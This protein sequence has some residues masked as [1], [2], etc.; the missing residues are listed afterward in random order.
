MASKI[1]HLRSSVSGK[2]PTAGQLE[3]G[4]IAL[5]TA[6][7]K[8][9]MKKSDNSI[10]EI[11]K[12]IHDEDT[13][14]YIDESGATGKI[15]LEADGT[16][17]AEI[18]VAAMN[19][20]VP[21]VIEDNDSITIRESSANGTSGV[22]IKV[23]TSLA[24]TY[25]FTLPP[26]PGIAGQI[27]KTNGSGTLT[28][29]DPGLT[30]NMI[31]VDGTAGNDNNDGLIKPVASIKRACEIAS[32]LIYSP[33]TAP[34]A[35]TND[36][37]QLLTLNKSFIQAEVIAYIDYQIANT[38]GIWAGFTY[39][40]VTCSRDT[41][42]IVDAVIYDLKYGGNSKSVEA[43]KAYYRG[44]TSTE[45]V[46]NNQKAQTLAAIDYA[47][48]IAADIIRNIALTDDQ[49][50]N[51]L[52]PFQ[53]VL[54]QTIDAGY[55]EGATVLTAH[56]DLWDEVLTILELGVLQASAVVY[57]QF[58]TGLVTIKIGTGEYLENN[59]I[60]VPDSVSI[61]GDALRAVIIRPLNA[62]KD[63]FRVRNG[64]YASGFTFRDQLN[65]NGV[66]IAT[67]N[68][69]VS[70]DDVG[71]FTTSRHSYPDLPI[72]KPLMTISPYIQNCSIISFLGGNGCNIDGSKVFSP[73]TP[74]NQI[75]SENPVAGDAPL[76]N[77][78]MVGNAFTILSFGGTGY[79]VTNN[80]YSQI[81]SCFQIFCKNG[82]YAQSGGYLSITNSATNFGTYALRASGFRTTAFAFDKGVIATN[83]VDGSFQTLDVIG[84]QRAPTEHYV[85]R[86]V[87]TNFDD[88]TDTYKSS[89]A[90]L[91]FSAN[92]S[93]VNIANNKFVITAHGL[94]NG[95]RVRYNANGNSDIFGIY[96]ETY[97]Y[98]SLINV[99]E[100]QLFEDEELTNLSEL[101]STSSGT[102]EFISGD[103]EFFIQEIKNAHSTYQTIV[104]DP[105]TYSF[106]VGQ[107]ITG[108]VSGNTNNAYVYSW[109]AGTRTLVVSINQVVVSGVTSY[110]KF[111]STST[112]DVDSIG[113]TNIGITS[114]ND[115]TDLFS[116]KLLLRSTQTGGQVATIAQLPGFN[117]Y[118]HRPSI[119]NSS[120][121]TW[122]YAGSG[123]DYNAL[124]VNGGLTNSDYEQYQDLPGRVYTSGT[125]EQGDFKVGR[126]ITAQNRTGNVTFT[127]KVSIAQLDSLQLSLSDVTIEAIST[128][129]TLGDNDP[130]GASHSRLT[131]QLAQRTFMNNRL[132]DFLDKQVTSS[133]VPGAVVQLNS[134]GKINPDLI[135]PIRTNSNFTLSKFEARLSLYEN[136]P[137]D[138]VLSGDNIIEAYTQEV[139]TLTSTA[140]VIK[141]ETITQANSGATG[142]VKAAVTA[143]S[144]ITL[145]SV[146]GTF[147]DN[148]ADTLSGSTSGA[149][150]TYPSSVSGS[151]SAQDN[152]FLSTDSESQFLIILD[153][154]DSTVHN[155]V[156]G[157]IVQ[158]ANTLAEGEVIEYREGV[159]ITTNTGSLAGGGGYGSAGIY[160]NVSLTGGTGTGVKAD[161]TVDGTGIVSSVDLVRGGTAYTAGDTL[162][163]SDAALG[164]RSGGSA[165]TIDIFS[166]ENRLYIDLAGNFIKFDASATTNEY[167]EDNNAET[168]SVTQAAFT[169][170][171]F[172]ANA[173]NN[174]IDYTENQ[175]IITDHGLVNGDPIEYDAN[176]NTEIG[177]LS[178]NVTYFAKRI[179]DN[180]FEAYTT[181]NLAP[182][183][184]VDFGS[185]STGTHVFRTRNV[186]T[187]GNRIFLPAHG[188]TSGTGIR[189][190]AATP[191]SGLTADN[192]Y[193]IGS[194]T[195]NSFTLHAL[196]NDAVE[197]VNG[198][199][200][201]AVSITATNAGTTSLR[202]QN[203]RIVG[204]VNTSSK[205]P[206]NYSSLNS[207]NI[208]AS[209]IVSGIISTSRLGTGTANQN[210]ALSG[211]GTYQKFIKTLK[212]TTGN[213][214]SIV[215]DNV[216]EG[217]ETV[218]YG[219]LSIQVDPVDPAAGDLSFTNLGVA[220]FSKEQFII[221]VDGEVTIKSTAEG[222]ELDA[223]T[224][225]GQQGS[226]YLNPE[227]NSRALPITKGGTNLTGYTSGNMLYAATN[228]S[229]N[230]DSLSTLA[231]GPTGSILKSNGSIPEWTTSISLGSLVIDDNFTVDT[232][233]LFIDSDEH[234][235][236]INNLTPAVIVDIT[237]TDAIRIPVGTTVQRPLTLK[238]GYIRYNTTNNTFE[239][240]NGN[241]WVQLQGVRDVDGDTFI[242][243]ETTPG[244]N[245]NTLRFYAGGVLVSELNAN[246]F[247]NIVVG[248]ILIEDSLITTTAS[249]S[250]LVLRAAGTGT[251]SIQNLLTVDVGAVIEGEVVVNESGSST[252]FRVETNTQSHALFVD[253]SA[254]AVGILTS[255]PKA[256]LQVQDYAIG[257]ETTTNSG[258]NAVKI[259]EWAVADFRT[260]KIIIQITDST[261]GE[262]Q[263]QEMMII[264]DSTN[265]AGVK[266]TEY[267]VL[268]TGSAALATFSTQ[269]SGGNI[270]LLATPST[271]STL[272]YK[273][274][275]TM[276]T[277]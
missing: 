61:M 263:A 28:F 249:N 1:K 49:D 153:P 22:V 27:L 133:S 206:D 194:I 65:V 247:S 175:I 242:S 2:N 224:L 184:Q 11:T 177:N 33:K 193:F 261:A 202:S 185:S 106:T 165:F 260:A 113:N 207:L 69:A 172:S 170:T 197:S 168:Q 112:I 190:I 57:G 182:A 232:D 88:V 118:L 68:F 150:S 100:F 254:D 91:Q 136:I 60:I 47:R 209:N 243:A 32:G 237:G 229:L 5:N 152:Y 183:N 41:G 154:Q 70:F 196:R 105:G 62:Q 195:T 225:G 227:N 173:V 45:E 167:I 191:P 176:G 76:Q 204:T 210:T 103:E 179:D 201:S 199:T 72:Q 15:V 156:T 145:V 187:S 231:I 3:E 214:I 148:A 31:I 23:P 40:D 90:T 134:S 228:L 34:S 223:T 250:N 246:G 87:N 137:A 120:A 35:A 264:H 276:I 241:V 10:R 277:V 158:G 265:N 97:Y 155:F 239:G 125:T 245:D 73:N 189:L 236:G 271:A 67:Y 50:G 126:F 251:I 77:P 132:G 181:Y 171:S 122:E 256:P 85:T 255:T 75:E 163:A 59:P 127:N 272:V 248:D 104:L 217:G 130:G 258:T 253:G 226:Y 192:F 25:N 7:G 52:A 119:V 107:E 13:Q 101:G 262:Y 268:F 95:D 19:I 257:V 273:V 160:T 6:D 12:Q 244:S 8:V 220:A 164:G 26:T 124:P 46:I 36:A 108:T 80:A 44:T 116:A 212:V 234:K 205:N 269:V 169:S 138:E 147:T 42:Y 30:S 139:L 149:L 270:E 157:T 98:V 18:A 208:D 74:L 48:H 188:Y 24:N 143:G 240:Y 96:D 161:I 215:G 55:D 81:V 218:Y 203:V 238:Q 140:T 78:S 9:F 166:V 267:A 21:V 39:D 99:D 144:S 53:N 94:S 89:T 259:A 221:S 131:T 17:V 174:E 84:F 43:G 92:S 141:G 56:N 142:V 71:D 102:H 110:V 79:R 135:P 274:A 146:L 216:Q 117:L 64:V 178:N 275:K 129:V 58:N 123:T 121:H 83:G 211:D 37:I 159:A 16:N 200:Q 20:K 151:V 111:T 252:D 14:V 54:T 180:T 38:G 4:Q 235:I 109:N 114:V 51:V 63:M 82:S 162:S 115:K 213:P 219:D 29:E 198:T 66:P 186:S 233:T 222:G 266:S 230:T 93:T 86:F 128:D